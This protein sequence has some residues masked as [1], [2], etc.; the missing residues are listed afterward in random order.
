M[1]RF[2]RVFPFDRRHLSRPVATAGDG[3]IAWR[4]QP[5]SRQVEVT[6]AKI[7]NIHREGASVIARGLPND[8]REVWIGLDELPLEWARCR[9]CTT[10]LALGGTRFHLAFREPCAPGLLEMAT[11]RCSSADHLTF[12][13]VL[14]NLR[15]FALT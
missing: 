8:C 9:V 2:N 10:R 12:E 15:W 3:R 1:T 4:P 11:A 6:A 14:G 5:D 13:E 7:L